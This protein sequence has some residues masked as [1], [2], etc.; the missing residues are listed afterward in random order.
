M[1]YGSR[2]GTAK[3]WFAIWISF[4]C[5]YALSGCAWGTAQGPE[6]LLRQ[7]V[8]GLAGTDD[9]QF[10]GTASLAIG[11]N[12]PQESAVFEGKVTGHNEL[13]MTFGKS[14]NGS[15]NAQSAENGKQAIL[16]RRNGQWVVLESESSLEAEL[17]LHWNPLSK[18]ESLNAMA[19]QVSSEPDGKD[20]KRTIVTVLPD[21]SDLTEL[22]RTRLAE[23]MAALDA[24]RKLAELR[25]RHNLSSQEAEN[26]RPE[27]ER[28]LEAV[29]KRLEEA[30][31]S[32]QAR[33][34]YRIGIDRA[35]K[36][37]L[38]MEI[39]SQLSYSEGGMP[40][41]EKAHIRYEFT[42]YGS[43]NG[44]RERSPTGSQ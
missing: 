40:K 6:D 25:E 28:N 38:D 37:P 34:E 5:C 23:Q 9:F 16:S 19:K 1:L 27:L 22:Y 31:N 18:L 39:R 7:A 20:G 13:V 10:K 36:L 24:D 44:S 17:M 2:H 15:A 41:K 42:G 33:E 21:D 43:G 29:R 12:E 30:A 35:S 8:S 4:A 14:R 3:R 11:E 32:L 26:M